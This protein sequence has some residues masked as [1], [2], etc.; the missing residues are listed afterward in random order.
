MPQCSARPPECRSAVRTPVSPWLTVEWSSRRQ[1]RGRGGDDRRL[2]G[3]R[4]GGRRLGRGRGGLRR[5]RGRR[6]GGGGRGRRG[7]RGGG[8][9]R[10]RRGGRLARRRGRRRPPCP[11]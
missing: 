6:L 10:G 2:G 7:R 3:R 9:P 8:G 1:R 5:R 11:A 4:L